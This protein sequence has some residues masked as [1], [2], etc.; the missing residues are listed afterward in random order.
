MVTPISHPHEDLPKGVRTRMTLM[1]L[2]S[3][4][5]TC[6]RELKEI[7]DT[8]ILF[9]LKLK[10]I[11]VSV[12]YPDASPSITTYSC[13]NRGSLSPV[14]LTKTINST[15]VKFFYRVHKKKIVNLPE[16]PDR[17][18]LDKAEVTLAFPIDQDHIP[19]IESQYLFA[20]LPVRKFGFNVS[21]S[22]FIVSK[23]TRECVLL[24]I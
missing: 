7:P 10:T 2:P 3:K 11:K 21:H 5:D 13:T 17:E 16:H 9:L 22:S 4:F 6:K 19:V 18:G 14:I 20:F 23:V 24:L 12:Y 1:L 15:S 8:F